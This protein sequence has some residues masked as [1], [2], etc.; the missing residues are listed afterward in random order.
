MGTWP[1]RGGRGWEGLGR[2]LAGPGR[3]GYSSTMSLIEFPASQPPP[4]TAHSA[5]VTCQCLH[6]APQVPSRA[7]TPTVLSLS[8]SLTPPGA[9]HHSRHRKCSKISACRKLFVNTPSPWTPVLPRD[10]ILKWLLLSVRQ[11][12]SLRALNTP[13]ISCEKTPSLLFFSCP[14]ALLLLL[15]HYVC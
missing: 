11:L 10:K 2:A 14:A 9:A 3:L 1:A 12:P 5:S 13:Q 4:D 15:H 7:S 8:L 6:P